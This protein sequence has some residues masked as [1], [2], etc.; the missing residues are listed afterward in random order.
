[1]SGFSYPEWI[2]EVY[3]EGTKRDGMLAAYAKIFNA[4]EINMSFRRT[5]EETTIDKW[6]DAVPA[7]ASASR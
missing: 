3:P 4:V 1:M 5:P 2:G 7:T 6:R